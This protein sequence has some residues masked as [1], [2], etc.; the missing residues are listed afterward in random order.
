MKQEETEERGG[1]R[2]KKRK[3][4]SPEGN[5]KPINRVG[6]ATTIER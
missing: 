3:Q 5:K 4:R 6:G 1:N 2:R